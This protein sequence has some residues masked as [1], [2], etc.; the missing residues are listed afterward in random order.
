M[1]KKKN[2]RVS[3]HLDRLEK[4]FGKLLEEAEDYGI[5]A[6]DYNYGELDSGYWDAL[7]ELAEEL[8][9]L[10]TKCPKCGDID[11]PGG[12]ACGAIHECGTCCPEHL[13]DEPITYPYLRKED[14]NAFFL[15][16]LPIPQVVGG[17]YRVEVTKDKIGDLVYTLT[18][19]EG[20]TRTVLLS[21]HHIGDGEWVLTFWDE[22]PLV[23]RPR[24]DRCGRCKAKVEAHE[25]DTSYDG[26]KRCPHCQGC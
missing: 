19:V 12:C 23:D 5:S 20:V 26:W 9:S 17:E 14:L 4:R 7:E 6:S 15:D 13:P 1:S 25:W 8:W 10:S 18:A 3:D 21:S 22:D 24:Y 2:T 11:H 16:T